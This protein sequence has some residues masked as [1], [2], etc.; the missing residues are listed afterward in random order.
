MEIQAAGDVV[1]VLSASVERSRR[2]ELSD[3]LDEVFAAFA[4]SPQ[5][6]R[7][8]LAAAQPETATAQPTPAPVEGAE[9]GN[10]TGEAPA[11]ERYQDPDG[12]FSL[13][14]PA[15]LDMQP[16]NDEETG[17]SLS[18]FFAPGNE[19][20]PVIA[21]GFLA[22]RYALDKVSPDE[23]FGALSDEEWTRFVDQYLLEDMG[24]VVVE[25]HRN[26]VLHT[27]YFLLQPPQ[28]P[29]DAGQVWMWLEETDGVVAYLLAMDGGE[30]LDGADVFHTALTTFDWS[31]PAAQAAIV[32]L[33]QWP[34]PATAPVP[35]ADPLGLIGLMSLPAYPFQSVAF[36]G[37]TLDYSFGANPAEGIVLVSLSDT[38]Q[39]AF[40]ADQWEQVATGVEETL[41]GTLADSGLGRNP[42]LLHARR[43]CSTSPRT[44]P[45]PTTPSCCAPP[46]TSTKWRS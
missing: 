2:A 1:A 14:V 19:D 23:A 31:P 25:E 29:S 44:K 43:T 12:V 8:S 18:G 30:N 37:D 38:G 5:L 16:G 11:G 32:N 33:L 9:T 22:A 6:V 46:A 21:A 3:A 34:D 10:E 42:A 36:D 24:L 45:P 7:D 39:G 27:A 17:S 20:A 15:G 40:S 4:W 28:E 26:D 41:V 35:F 13:V